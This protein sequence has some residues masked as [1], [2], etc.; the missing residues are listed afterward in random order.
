MFA[1]SRE[2]MHARGVPIL[3]QLPLPFSLPLEGIWLDLVHACLWNVISGHNTRTSCIHALHNTLHI[4]RP[5]EGDRQLG[6]HCGDRA[7][8]SIHNVGCL[9][10]MVIIMGP[11]VRCVV[12]PAIYLPYDLHGSD[13]TQH[14]LE[15]LAFVTVSY[16]SADGTTIGA[17]ALLTLA[18]CS[19]MELA[20]H[21]LTLYRAV[22]DALPIARPFLPFICQWPRQGGVWR[23]S[24]YHILL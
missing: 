4:R 13:A 1:L 24:S 23:S 12:E 21:T 8:C 10:V 20:S 2:V 6:E 11:W 9:T 7:L 5:S 19:S 22:H 15:N 3:G 14:A 18:A 16:R 17:P